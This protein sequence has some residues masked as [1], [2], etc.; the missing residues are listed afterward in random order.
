[1]QQGNRS[2]DFFMFKYCFTGAG[3]FPFPG[4]NWQFAEHPENN[5]IDTQKLSV[6]HKYLVDSTQMTG[7]MVVQ[8]GKVVFTYGDI[9]EN[10][11][12]ASC[13]KSVLAMLYGAYITSGEINLH[14]TLKELGIDDIG[15]L[16][17]QEKE[18]TIEV[19]S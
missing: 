5:G 14:T 17:P 2:S 18:A 10:S 3:K 19:S 8:H 16:L 6:L 9:E 11:Y 12:I 1:M 4:K 15:G 13:R 7:F